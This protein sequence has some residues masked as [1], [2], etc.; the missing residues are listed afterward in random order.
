MRTILPFDDLAEGS[1]AALRRL[2]YRF[3]KNQSQ[4]MV[5]FEVLEPAEFLVRIESLDDDEFRPQ[6]FFG[7]FGGGGEGNAFYVVFTSGRSQSKSHVSS[8]VSELVSRLPRKPWE[9]LG[10]IEKRTSR[11][12]WQGLM[13]V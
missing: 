12:Y 3:Y 8:F 13:Q 2:G 5:E 11:A 10:F 6:P 4:R 9:G 1:D 7:I